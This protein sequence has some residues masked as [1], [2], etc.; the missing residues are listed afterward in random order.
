MNG[1]LQSPI[2]VTAGPTYEPIDAVRFLGNRSSGRMGVAIAE[3]ACAAGFSTLL[4]LGPNCVEP[5]ADSKLTTLRFRTTADLERLLVQYWP[6]QAQTLI[7]AAA[8]ADFRL[9]VQ[10]CGGV[11]DGNEQMKLARK[12]GGVTLD[13]EATPDLVAGCVARKK[14]SQHVIGFALEPA[15][16]LV[17]RARAKLKRKKL[18]AIVA[19]PLETMDAAG[20]DAFLIRDGK[21]LIE[22][23]GSMSKAEFATWLIGQLAATN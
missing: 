6:H 15:E 7:M 3:A 4:L 21:D 10:G 5:T 8:V 20:V 11:G 1:I 2:L 23:S 18:D 14:A 13:L 12:A 9:R 16:R 19:N 17:E 22:R